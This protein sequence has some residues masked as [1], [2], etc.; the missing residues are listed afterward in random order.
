MTSAEATTADLTIDCRG[1]YYRRL[2]ERIRAAAADGARR[3]VLRNVEGQR[4]IGAGLKFADLEILVEGVP[5]EDMAAFMDG[6]RID[7]ANNA[8]DAVGNTM[9][10]GKIVIR[11]L[12]GDV[13]GY[14]MR[15]GRIYVR[16]DV[17]YRV[18]I[19]MKG[20]MD[21][22]PLLVVGGRAGN[23]LGEYMAGGCLVVLGATTDRDQP[24]A[25]RFC[26]VGMHG[27]VMYI[28]GEYDKATLGREVKTFQLEDNDVETLKPVL[29]DFRSEFGISEP[30][31][32][33]ERYTRIVP[34]SARP[35]GR[36]YAY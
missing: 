24:A 30:L 13:I 12:A 22:Q 34:V 27:G 8:Q 20:Y 6:P 19:H 33:Y 5:G 21:K 4:Y 35:Y 36:L 14:G 17:G 23:F 7:V 9:N 18:G 11:G 3:I 1:V 31:D 25:G 28:R 2:N 16:E 15:G 10:E 29:R 26:A 32:D